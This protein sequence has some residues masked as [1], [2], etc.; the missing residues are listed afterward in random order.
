MYI[1]ETTAGMKQ[2]LTILTLQLSDPLENMSINVLKCRRLHY[3]GR[4]DNL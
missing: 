3:R 2:A 4:A 1:I